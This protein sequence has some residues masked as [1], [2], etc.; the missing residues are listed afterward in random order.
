MKI[1]QPFPW[2]AREGT[3]ANSCR[4]GVAVYA[5]RFPVG[6]DELEFVLLSNP[7]S[8]LSSVKAFDF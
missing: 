8:L 3:S 7:F 4:A 2:A 1:M 6:F 5:P